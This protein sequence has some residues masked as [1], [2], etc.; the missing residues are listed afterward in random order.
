MTY[1]FVIVSFLVA[2]LLGRM[3]IPYILFVTFRRR[4][5]DPVDSRKTHIGNIPRLGG[6]SFAPV[7]CCLLTLAVLL[8]YKFDYIDFHTK[9]PTLIPMFLVLM[10]GLVLLFMVGIADDLVGV[11]YKRK[12]I[13][14]IFAASLLPLSGLWINDLYGILKITYLSPWIGMPL[15]VFIV[16]LIM[17]AVNLIDGID[18]LCSG[19]IAAGSV[20]LGGLFVYNHAWLH[21]MFAFITAGVLFPFFYYNVF[22][23]SRRRHRIFMGD[24]GSLTLGFSISFMAISY[25]MNNQQ[26]MPFSEGAIVVAFSTVL[27]PVLDV[28][29]VMWWR[30]RHGKPLFKPDR[31]HIHHKFLR[32]GLSHHKAMMLILLL[33]FVFG[34]FNIVMVQYISNNIVLILDVVLWICFH[35]WFEK[36]ECSIY[37]KRKLREKLENDSL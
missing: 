3:I 2:V 16:V 27:I 31:N 36:K 11:N 18:G 20:T 29:R 35:L 22:G 15:T 10:C 8:M 7:Q 37:S 4:L 17:N 23:A 12:F 32:I 28:A 25:A 33:A 24:T 13:V 21:A 9:T 14:Q 34:L 6:V 19:L 26:I 5:F 30:F 1:I